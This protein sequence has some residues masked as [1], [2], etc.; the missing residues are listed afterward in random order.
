ME[1]R[2]NASVPDRSR[3]W[4][5]PGKPG[6]PAV[7]LHCENTA[8]DIRSWTETTNAIFET[9]AFDNQY[10]IPVM[11][12][13]KCIGTATVAQ[14]ENKWVIAVYEHGFDLK[15]E[16]DKD[17]ATCFADV[18]QLNERGFLVSVDT[19][20]NSVELYEKAGNAQLTREIDAALPI[21]LSREE[22]I[23]LVRPLYH[24]TNGKLS[25]SF[26]FQ[27]IE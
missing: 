11:S 26:Y 18:V 21:E 5:S 23:R 2:K 6:E 15:T 19:E 22:Q 24:L 17:T 14:Q 16:V 10:M 12:N 7:V 9:L 13:G 20:W 25:L 8:Q 1:G 4:K 3:L 27:A